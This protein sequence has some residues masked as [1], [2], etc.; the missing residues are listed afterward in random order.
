MIAI[1]YIAVFISILLLSALI[2]ALRAREDERSGTSAI[3]ETRGDNLQYFLQ[4]QQALSDDDREYVRNHGGEKLARGMERE[5]RRVV[6][7]F[8]RALNDEFE[9]LMRMARVVASLSPEVETMQEFERLKLT[10]VFHWRLLAIRTQLSFGLRPLPQL[11]VAS[12]LVSRLT[13]QMEAAMKEL[14]E[15]AALAGESASNRGVNFG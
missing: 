4:V 2:W 15:K 7:D 6:L 1:L 8:L 9:H 3:E 10:V 14:G 11:E 13:V 5:R 12:E